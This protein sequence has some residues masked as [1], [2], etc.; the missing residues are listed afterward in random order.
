MTLSSQLNYQYS[1]KINGIGLLL[2]PFYFDFTLQTYSDFLSTLS[3]SPLCTFREYCS[4]SVQNTIVLRH[5]V[6]GRPLNSLQFA[7]MQHC[8]GM[9]ASYYFRIVPDSFDPLIIEAISRMGHEIGYHY[10]DVSLA[11]ASLRVEKYKTKDPE[12]FRERLLEKALE[13]FASNLAVLR[14]Y[15]DIHTICMHGSPLSP[16][17]SRLLWTKYN[18]RDFGLIGEPYLDIDFSKVA[19]YTDTGRCWDG[20]RSVIRD[21]PL[22]AGLAID[23]ATEKRIRLGERSS[24]SLRSFP[25]FHSTFDIIKAA[26]LRALPDRV[27]FTFHPQRWHDCWLPWTQELVWQ[28]C[29]NIVKYGV[30]QV[31]GRI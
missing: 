27:M 2:K 7:Q 19:Y 1:H 10:E 29:K 31:R 5:D 12:I 9:M 23:L 15:A 14:R 17:D 8:F 21:K 24:S 22:P 25:T 30:E 28:N 26:E 11:A 3:S 20:D 6:D 16:W 4:L 13:S 18:Y